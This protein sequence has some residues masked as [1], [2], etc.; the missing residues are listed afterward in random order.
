MIPKLRANLLSFLQETFGI[1]KWDAIRFS[2]L[3]KDPALGY[4]QLLQ[5]TYGPVVVTE[6]AVG[7][8]VAAVSLDELWAKVDAV[9][10]TI[11]DTMVSPEPCLGFGLLKVQGPVQVEI[12]DSYTQQGG[13]STTTA[14]KT[15]V[16][17][18]L[19]LQS[20]R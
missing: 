18:Q 10:D 2:M 17:F 16:T 6:W 9:L 11:N 13:I 14:F 20:A 15:A 7:I 1:T 3:P 12:P 19:T 4:F 5:A 8:G